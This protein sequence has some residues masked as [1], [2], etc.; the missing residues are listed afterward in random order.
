MLTKRQINASLPKV[1]M[2]PSKDGIEFTN[3]TQVKKYY[4]PCLKRLTPTLAK[5]LVGKKVYALLGQNY[6]QPTSQLV[7]QKSISQIKIV[8][9]TNE[10]D[11]VDPKYKKQEFIVLEEDHSRFLSYKCDSKFHKYWSTGSGCDPVYIFTK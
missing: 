8:G 6:W 10:E 9:F 5:E 1:F 7:K 11:Q 2:D 3:I 4:G